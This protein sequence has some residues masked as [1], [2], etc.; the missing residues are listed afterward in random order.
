[1]PTAISP[2]L[3]F[4]GDYA[5]WTGPEAIT[6]F[7]WGWGAVE[8]R[9]PTNG[10][11]WRRFEYG[12][13]VAAATVRNGKLLTIR[14]GEGVVL[15]IRDAHTGAE[16][17][18]VKLPF[19]N[20]GDLRVNT[21]DADRWIVGK[22]ERT[23]ILNLSTNVITDA[24]NHWHWN[25]QGFN[26][27]RRIG[28]LTGVY[29]EDW[30][31]GFSMV[32][33][34]AN[35]LILQQES[36]KVAPAFFTD[37]AVVQHVDNGILALTAIEYRTG[38]TLWRFDREH[39]WER[40]PKALLPWG[41]KTVLVSQRRDGWQRYDV[42]GA[43]G[44][45]QS[46]GNLAGQPGGPVCVE[47]IGNQ[48]WIGS[49]AGLSILAPCTADALKTQTIDPATPAAER[50]MRDFNANFIGSHL[51]S[52]QDDV[53]IDGDLSDWP[54]VAPRVA[55]PADHRTPSIPGT[56]HITDVR[57]RSTFDAN[58]VAFAVEVTETTGAP[59][60][61]RLG[62]DPR[63]DDGERPPVVVLG[64]DQ[65]EGATRVRVVDGAWDK[66]G[67]AGTAEPRARATRTLTGWRFEVGIPWPLLRSRP[68]WRP[69]D[70]RWFRYG[71]LTEAP[72]DTVEFGHGLSSATDWALWP[73]MNLLNESKRK[74]AK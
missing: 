5:V 68:E 39:D 57:L 72:G 11:L 30:N 67:D 74:K 46:S 31:H 8:V 73:G 29:R 23:I 48:L 12:R 3:I 37:H 51:E 16:S 13:E 69:G 22:G 17:P 26:R 47:M 59:V 9:D 32:Y 38:K 15:D 45:V 70:R 60:S 49:S 33:D 64:I 19:D 44:K 62:L 41:D 1:M 10:S 7:K 4:G 66:A 21:L 50:M 6:C 63:G 43:D 54:E 35:K 27:A 24:E 53:S 20:I 14:N 40:W 2:Q 42:L 34:P 56:A 25:N 55:T 36:Y 61:L 18:V 71:L 65:V 52:A 58:Q 28:D